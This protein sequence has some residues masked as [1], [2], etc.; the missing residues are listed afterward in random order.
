[1]SLKHANGDCS[2]PSATDA[3]SFAAIRS[4]AFPIRTYWSGLAI[5]EKSLSR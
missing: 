4:V 2:N 1:H 3:S 5:A